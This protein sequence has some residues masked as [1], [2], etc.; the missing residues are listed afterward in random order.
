MNFDVELIVHHEGVP[1]QSHY[2]FL[3]AKGAELISVR[4][5]PLNLLAEYELTGIFS[6]YDTRRDM[7]LEQIIMGRVVS[8]FMKETLFPTVKDLIRYGADQLDTGDR[9]T[10]MISA[11]VDTAAATLGALLPELLPFVAATSDRLKP[12]AEQA[13][14]SSLK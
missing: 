10:N 8:G 3:Q 2:G 12:M 11:A 6:S 5:T 7:L 13:A 1:D 9:L 4:S 14:R